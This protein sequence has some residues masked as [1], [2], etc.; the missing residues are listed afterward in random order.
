MPKENYSLQFKKDAVALYEDNV[1]LSLASAAQDLGVNRSTLYAWVQKLGLRGNALVWINSKSKQS[2]YLMLS[3]SAGWR[4]K[5]AGFV[6]NVTSYGKLLNISR[7][8]QAGDP[9]PVC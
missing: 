8:R 9:L 3:V 7:K 1:D 5:T 4:K 6:K 2:K